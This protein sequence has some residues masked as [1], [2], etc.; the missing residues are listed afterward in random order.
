MVEHGFL[1]EESDCIIM[2]LGLIQPFDSF[3]KFSD[4]GRNV[5]NLELALGSQHTEEIAN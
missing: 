4:P 3:D 5:V 2:I 1:G